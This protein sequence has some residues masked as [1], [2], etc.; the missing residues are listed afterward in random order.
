[1]KRSIKQV[2]IALHFREMKV[3]ELLVFAR[4]IK[5]N[6]SAD[7]DITIDIAKV[8]KLN[9]QTTVLSNTVVKR[10]TILSKSLT[11]KQ[12][13]QATAL[14]LT[15]QE[16]AKEVEQKANNIIRGNTARATLA[17]ER[18]GFTLK[19]ETPKAGRKFEIYKFFTSGVGVRVKAS[20]DVYLYHWRWSPDGI[21]WI[22]LPD[23][24]GAIIII[25]NL[26]HRTILHF[27]S[28]RTLKTKG[29]TTVDAY[30]NEPHWSDSISETIH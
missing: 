7:P 27:Q 17:I 28:S 6:A 20:D 4:S 15:L 26:P 10:K 18:I 16:I 1:M 8:N 5:L 3:T 19:I 14:M 22:R 29:I 11:T 24:K 21:N 25:S 2:K 13:K 12:G 30:V 23:T 9:R